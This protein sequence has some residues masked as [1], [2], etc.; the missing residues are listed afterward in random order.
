MLTIEDIMLS[1]YNIKVLKLKK[2]EVGAA[3]DTY[4]IESET[5]KYILKHL[6]ISH[7]RYHRYAVGY[8]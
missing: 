1:A 7:L 4:L 2:L 3:S 6:I 5:D 8:H